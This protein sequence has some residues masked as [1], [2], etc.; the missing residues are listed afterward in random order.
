MEPLILPNAQPATELQDL[1][2][3][4][5]IVAE[6]YWGDIYVGDEFREDGELP[7]NTWQWLREAVVRD[8]KTDANG[9]QV[10]IGKDIMYATERKDGNTHIRIGLQAAFV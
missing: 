2:A 1:L 4:D 9:R 7:T 3:Q 5:F 8:L 6:E 10:A